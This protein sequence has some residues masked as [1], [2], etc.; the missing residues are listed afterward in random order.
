LRALHFRDRAEAGNPSR[1]GLRALPVLAD[2]GY[3]V[4]HLESVCGTRKLVRQAVGHVRVEG[5]AQDF[6]TACDIAADP[7]QTRQPT[8]SLRFD[9]VERAIIEEAFEAVRRG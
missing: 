3:L 7:M 8:L 4:G 1:A 6:L 9:P 5:D 2:A